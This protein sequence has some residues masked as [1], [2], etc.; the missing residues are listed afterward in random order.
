MKYQ[1]LKV[2]NG[3]TVRFTTTDTLFPIADDAIL[4]A[5]FYQALKQYRRHIFENTNYTLSYLL[6]PNQEELLGQFYTLAKA[7]LTLKDPE[8]NVAHEDVFYLCYM[9][10]QDYFTANF[11]DSHEA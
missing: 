2:V 7:T 5:V 1:I 9:D 11:G 4:F 10:K 6:E 8:T 3:G